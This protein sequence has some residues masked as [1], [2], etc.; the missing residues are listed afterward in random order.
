MYKHW[1]ISLINSV[2]NW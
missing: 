1:K 2:L